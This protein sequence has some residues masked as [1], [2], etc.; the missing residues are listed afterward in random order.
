MGG[1]HGGYCGSLLWNI[2]CASF[3]ILGYHWLLIATTN[4]VSDNRE[5]EVCGI[6]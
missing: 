6:F 5:F 4:L 3:F 1:Y 2:E